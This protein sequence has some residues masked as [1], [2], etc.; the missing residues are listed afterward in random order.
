MSQD[1]VY[2]FTLP[3][4]PS[5]NRMYRRGRHGIHLSNDARAWKQAAHIAALQVFPEPLTGEIV[6]VWDFYMA[7]G[8]SDASNRI[9]ALEDALQGAAYFNDRQIVSGT[10]NK[11]RDANNPRVEATIW[12]RKRT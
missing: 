4:P 7:D 6:V 8:R 9:K 10:Y 11:L 1:S 12:K 5:V 2:S 3:L